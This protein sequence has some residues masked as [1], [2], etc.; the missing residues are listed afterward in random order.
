MSAVT[1]H[2]Q[3][4]LVQIMS[5]ALEER[6]GKVSICGRIITDLRFAGNAGIE[7]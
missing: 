3:H 7:A 5:D 4:F 1:H 2:I 6:G